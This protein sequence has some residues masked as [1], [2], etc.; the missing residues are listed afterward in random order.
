MSDKR[1]RHYNEKNEINTKNSATDSVKSAEDIVAGRNAVLEVLHSGHSVNRLLLANG[2]QEGSIKEI[3]ALAKEEHIVITYVERSK[4]DKVAGNIK[5][6][7]VVAYV[8]PIDYVPLIDL[9]D[10]VSEKDR[11][12]FLVLLDEL[13]DPH[14]LGALL[15]T[16]DSAGVD[17][18]IIPKRR[19]CSLSSIVAKVSAGAVEYVPV[20]RVGSM[21][22]ALRLLK[23]KGYWIA[24]ADVGGTIYTK[25]DLT[26]ALALV[27][28]SEGHG[29][30][31]LIKE[32]CDFIVSLPMQGHLSSLNAA[33][34]G[35]ILMYEAMRQR[36]LQHS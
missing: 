32:E 36:G 3:I 1:P 22:Q 27:I 10:S 13:E 26:G 17:G 19:S 18:I 21:T 29:I 8:P 25:A 23:K 34:A 15:R 14:N 30:G 31:R 4:L 11:A 9:L 24:G 2:Q 20:S 5:H 28:G 12:P 35:S 6:Q 16:A 7:G 33:V